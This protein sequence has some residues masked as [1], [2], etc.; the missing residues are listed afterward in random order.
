MLN[1]HTRIY[2]FFPHRVRGRI[3][4]AILPSRGTASFLGS[5][6][7]IT[8][9][10]HITR[11]VCTVLFP[12]LPTASSLTGTKPCGPVSFIFTSRLL[13]H[14]YLRE[15]TLGELESNPVYF[16]YGKRFSIC[17]HSASQTWSLTINI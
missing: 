13:P 16:L 6:K 17:I 12:G 8:N 4:N 2:K 7:A 3:W 11:K 1:V 10:T 14:N 5:L 9:H 15:T